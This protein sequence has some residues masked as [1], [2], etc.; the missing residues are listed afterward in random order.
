MTSLQQ[1]HPR[2]L[3]AGAGLGGL[4]AALALLRKGFDVNV[5]EQ[6]NELGE[7][8]AGLQIS[9]NGSRVLYALGLGQQMMSLACEATGKEIRLWST[10]QTWKLFDLGAESVARYGYPYLT[11]Y[12]PDLLGALANAVQQEKPNA[13][14][15]GA[16]VTS[17][18][19]EGGRVA[20]C[21]ADGQTVEGDALVGA[22]GIHSCVRHCLFGAETAKFTG[23]I[24]WRGVIAMER[25]PRQMQRFVGVNWVG[26]GRHVVQ[27]P[28]R[29]G[30]LMNFVGIVERSDWQVESWTA[31]GT[32]DELAGD[33]DGWHADVQTMIKAIPTPYKWALMLRVPLARWSAARATLLGDACHPTLPMMAQG[34]VQAIEDGFVLARALVEHPGEVEKALARYEAARRDRATRVVLASAEN[35]QRFH[36]PALAD[37]A[38]AQAYVDREWAEER[39]RDRYDWLFRYEADSAPV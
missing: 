25:L 16:R 11:V 17:C 19:Q 20:L 33:F 18:I 7:V 29:R 10:G 37:V 3:I 1:R 24:A 9:A 15:L 30:E 28:V 13:I 21:L 6:A 12:R 38:G 35:A 32:T 39:V 22:D 36:N 4:T 14:H 31:R 8:G 34:A 26:P 2:V 5:Y 27:Y 23:M